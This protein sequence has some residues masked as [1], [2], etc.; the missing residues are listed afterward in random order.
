M[1][2]PENGQDSE[3]RSGTPTS[4]TDEDITT[5]SVESTLLFLAC[6]CGRLESWRRRL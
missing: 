1:R 2:R 5:V 4:L 6:G 3:N